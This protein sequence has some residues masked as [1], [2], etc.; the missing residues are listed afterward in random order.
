LVGGSLLASGASADS[1]VYAMAPF[2]I[3]AGVAVIILSV[4]A[5]PAR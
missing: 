1:V 2:A 3:T 4:A 5:K